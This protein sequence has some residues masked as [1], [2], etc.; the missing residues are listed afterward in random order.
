M[1]K[2]YILINLN[3]E[4]SAETRIE[5]SRERTRWAVF[6]V[7][8]LIFLG[9]NSRVLMINSGYNDIIDKKKS[10]IGRLKAKIEQLQSRGKN[11]SKDDI[12]SFAEL[13]QS[14]FLWASNM[15]ELGKM[16]PDDMVITGLRFKR[17]KMIITGIALTFDDRKDFEIIDEYL[18]TLKRNKNF[19]EQFSRIKL[20]DYGR[21][22]IRGQEIIR[23]EFEASIKVKAIK[24]FS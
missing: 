17:K 9:A 6:F 3:K 13:E 20:E 18:Q 11:L 19:S 21:I 22:S 16:T 15:E 10:E 7:L 14:R 1:A 4:E 23:F 5:R 12:L 24:E 8:I 2:S